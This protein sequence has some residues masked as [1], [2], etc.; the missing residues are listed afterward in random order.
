MY[1][2]QKRVDRDSEN[3]ANNDAAKSIELGVTSATNAE[4]IKRE[5]GTPAMDV[6]EAELESL[7]QNG[8]AGDASSPKITLS[9][10]SDND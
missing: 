5:D 4:P 1:Y 3:D 8:V 2:I 6:A 7:L 9:A 10:A